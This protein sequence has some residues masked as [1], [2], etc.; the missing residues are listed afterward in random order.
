VLAYLDGIS[1]EAMLKTALIASGVFLAFLIGE[2]K[3]SR[4]RNRR[5]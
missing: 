5:R 1:T 4:Y 2:A 3:L